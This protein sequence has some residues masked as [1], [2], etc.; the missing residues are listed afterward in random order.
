SGPPPK[1]S[2]VT[3][4][5]VRPRRLRIKFPMPDHGVTPGREQVIGIVVTEHHLAGCTEGKSH[6]DARRPLAP[7]RISPERSQEEESQAGG[8]VKVSGCGPTRP[9][10]PRSS[11]LIAW[12]SCAGKEKSNRSMFSSMR[13]RDTVFGKIMSPRCRC[14]RR[15]ICEADLP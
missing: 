3:S 1:P 10:S 12:N 8:S 7:H 9:L 13:S 15:M 6:R 5:V 11:E 2:L 14:Q 4:T